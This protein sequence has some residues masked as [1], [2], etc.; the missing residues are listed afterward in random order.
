[1]E[2]VESISAGHGIWWDETTPL[3]T[4]TRRQTLKQRS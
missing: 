1:M 2:G 4:R 3:V